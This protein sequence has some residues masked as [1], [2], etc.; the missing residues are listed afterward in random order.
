MSLQRVLET[1]RKIGMPVIITD[2]SGRDPMVI[3][4]LEQFEAMAGTAQKG[5]SVTKKAPVELPRRVPPSS[6]SAFSLTDSAEQA[7]ADMTAE[8]AKARVEEAATQLE[9]VVAKS[10]ENPDFS[11]EER[12]YLEPVEDKGEV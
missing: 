10:P 4:P 5:T 8:R 6:D 3:L 1:G 2:L 11:L 9:A 12:F 7:F